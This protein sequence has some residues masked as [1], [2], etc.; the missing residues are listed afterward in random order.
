MADF[1][2]DAAAQIACGHQSGRAKPALENPTARVS[3]GGQRAMTV[4]EPY[5]VIACAAGQNACLTASFVS[6][7]VRVKSMGRPL[8]LKSSNSIA[9]S[10]QPL[11]PISTQTRVKAT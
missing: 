8:V 6:G 10:G 3:L 9:S 1:V 2:I 11:R 5:E 4:G 7:S